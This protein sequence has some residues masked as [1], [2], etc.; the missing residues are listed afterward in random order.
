MPIIYY[1]N[2][3]HGFDGQRIGKFFSLVF[4]ITGSA[5]LFLFPGYS[6]KVYPNRLEIDEFFSFNKTYPY[7]SITKIEHTRVNSEKNGTR[8]GYTLYFRDI[9]SGVK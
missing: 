3:K 6:L 4:V 5:V 2:L 7:T 9:D 1:T 8:E